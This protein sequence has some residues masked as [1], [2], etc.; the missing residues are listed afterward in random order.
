MYSTFGKIEN[1]T[2]QEASDSSSKLVEKRK[3]FSNV[4]LGEVTYGM[5]K[6]ALSPG[7]SILR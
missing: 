7:M 5:A 2:S 4:G 1:S 6:C 3:D